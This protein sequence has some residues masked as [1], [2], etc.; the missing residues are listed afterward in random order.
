M[1]LS[2]ASSAVFVAAAAAVLTGRT[3]LA[4]PAVVVGFGLLLISHVLARRLRPG[5]VT[6]GP[7]EAAVVREVRERDGE[8]AAVRRLRR[9][10]PG[11]ALSDAV[12]FDPRSLTVSLAVARGITPT[13][14]TH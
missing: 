5:P 10:H 11:L 14:H 7:D 1:I 6:P 3:T 4:L 12:R 13:W 9:G 8:M 2:L